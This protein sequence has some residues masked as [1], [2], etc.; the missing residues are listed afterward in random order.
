M[1]FANVSIDELP[2][3]CGYVSSCVM[4]SLFPQV[5]QEALDQASQGRTCIVVAHR[6]STIQNA[7]RIVVFQDGVV[8]EQGTHQQ[9]LAQKGFYHTLVTKQMGHSH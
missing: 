8:V 6:L 5:V 4:V 9:L 1:L 7:D 2:K 3:L